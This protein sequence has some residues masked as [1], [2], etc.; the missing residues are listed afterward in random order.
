M[1]KWQEDNTHKN[2]VAILFWSKLQYEHVH[3]KFARSWYLKYTY[4]HRY[5]CS[6]N[7]DKSNRLLYTYL[8]PLMMGRI[9]H[10]NQQSP[11]NKKNTT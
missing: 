8:I 7:N 6:R 4:Y 9:Q 11:R 5:Q 10:S 2:T 1:S 3:K